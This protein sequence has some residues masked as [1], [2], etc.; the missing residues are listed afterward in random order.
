LLRALSSRK[1]F[2][3][4]SVRRDFI[5]LLMNFTDENACSH[6]NAIIKQNITLSEFS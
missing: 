6:V 5:L 4:E 2:K 3:F 1:F